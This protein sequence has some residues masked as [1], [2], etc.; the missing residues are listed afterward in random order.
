[1]GDKALPNVLI[2]GGGFGGLESAFYVKMRLGEGAKLTLV[3]NRD[4][5]LFKPNT[6][7]IPF[8]LDPEV[9]KIPLDEPARRAGITLIHAT[10]QEIDP[11][12]RTVVADGQ[13]L[14]YDYLFVASGAGM[15]P[16]EVPGLKEHALTIWTVEEM[17]RLRQAFQDLLSDAHKGKRRQ[18]LFLV[19]PNNKCSG[20]LYEL[21]FMLDTWL[22]RNQ[23]RSVVDITWSTYEQGYIQAFGPR[24][25]E[26]V[27]AEFE[28]RGISGHKG[29]IVERVEKNEVVYTNGQKLPYDLLISFPPYVAST[30]FP[31]LP[32]DDRGFLRTEMTT[33]QVVGHPEIYAVGDA[34]DFPVKQ[35]FL[36][37]LQAD[38]AAEHL[39]AQ[40]AGK[41]PPVAFEPMS[42]CVM[43]QYDKATF[44]QVPLRVT[45]NP[46]RPVEVR[47]EVPS[48][49]RVG[50]SPLWRIGKKLLG[51][52]LPWRFRAGK[53]FHAGAPWK[54][55]EVGLKVMSK[56]LAS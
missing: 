9:L 54:A 26:V 14:R 23:A 19:P 8:G 21:V 56:V 41:E 42:M 34:G 32:T 35:A 50:S 3:S 30:F 11:G 47:T 43:E 38:V 20:P 55:M 5:F 18:V 31:G 17:L 53:P 40:I 16:E 48:L 4:Y 36:A 10:A 46:A 28:R 37:F 45:G 52:Y 15:R 2:I 33:R 27:T 39:A 1:M 24:L 13:T 22:R 12:K 29:Y 25:D 49:Y 51:I 6:I 44:A 7:Y